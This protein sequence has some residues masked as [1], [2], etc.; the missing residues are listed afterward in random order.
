MLPLAS[1]AMP[2]GPLNWPLPEPE[3]PTTLRNSPFSLNCSRRLL[4]ASAT[5]K[6]PLAVKAIDLGWAN[7][8]LPVPE[9]PK[10]VWNLPFEVHSA[11]EVIF[12]LVG[13]QG[14]FVVGGSSVRVAGQPAA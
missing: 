14:V 6:L 3:G 8:P 13:P 11:W 4:P 10:G 2:S 12:L 9:V 5:Q 1:I 7:W